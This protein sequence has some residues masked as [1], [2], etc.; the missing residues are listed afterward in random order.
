MS[1]IF[2]PPIPTQQHKK[3]QWG[4]L[5]PAASALAIANLAQQINTP[6][7]LITE[8]LHAAEQLQNNINF[9]NNSPLSSIFPDREILPYDH[10]SPHPDLTSDRLKLL[11]QLPQMTS[12][13]IIAA[14]PTLLS[15][16]PPKTFI[17]CHTCLFKIGMSLDTK[18]FRKQLT[19]AGYKNTT[20][21]TEHGEWLMRGS[22]IDIFP[23]GSDNPLRI[24][25]LDD[26]IDSLR[27]FDVETQRTIEKIEA[28]EILPATE[29]P[30]TDEAISHFRQSWRSRFSGNPMESPIY[31]N[32]SQGHA[33]PGIENYLPLF[34]ET[35]ASLID[36][37]P[38][39]TLIITSSSLSSNIEQY[40]KKIDYRYEQYRYDLSR[41]LCQPNQLFIS[42]E[43]LLASIAQFNKIIIQSS[44]N[45]TAHI[46][47]NTNTLPELSIQHKEKNPLKSFE[48][49]LRSHTGRCL[50]CAESSGRQEV[51]EDQLLA[52]NIKP[53]RYTTWDDFIADPSPIGIITCPLNAGFSIQQSDISIITEAELYGEQAVLQRK[54]R[55]QR[56]IDPDTLIKSLAEL[57]INDPVVHID[58]GIGKYLGLKNI[59]NNGVEAEFLTLEYANDAKIYVP[60]TSLHLISRYTGIDSKHAPLNTLGSA[61]WSKSKKKA[62]EKI[63]D[64]AAELLELNAKRQALPGYSFPLD[65]KEFERFQA[66]FSFQL[67]VDQELAIDAILKDMTSNHSMDRLICGDVGFGKTEVAMQAAFIAAIS[68]K[69]TSILVPTTLLANQHFQSFSDRFANWP[70][71]VG[72]ISR[73]QSTKQQRETLEQVAK[74]TIDIIIG[75]HKLLQKDIKIHDLGL[76]I[77]DE[78]HRFGVR[79]KEQIK[80]IRSE[81]DILSLTATPIPRTLNMALAGSR[82]I[83]IIAT[84]PERRLSI[85]TFVHDYS[86]SIIKEAILRESMRGGQLYCL[87]NDIATIQAMKEKLQA[88]SPDSRIA[89]AHGQMPKA[90]LEKI[91]SDFYHQKFNILLATTIIESGIDVPSANTIIINKADRFGLSQLH[92]LRG[93]V[94]RSHHQAYAYL[95]VEDQKTLSKDAKQRLEAIS[96]LED[97]GAGFTLATHDLEI[98]GAGEFLGEQQ[99]GH[100]QTLGYALY[101][102][103]LEQATKQLQAGEKPSFNL[104][105]NQYTE[106]DLG[107]SALIPD[108]YIHDVNTRLTLYKRINQC[109]DTG[110]LDELKAEVIDRFGPLA[111]S[112]NTLFLLTSLARQTTPLG[113]SKIETGTEYGY[114]TFIK[115]PPIEPMKIITLIQTKPQYYRMHKPNCLRFKIKTP[116]HNSKTDAIKSIIKTLS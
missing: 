95:L 50:I 37:L 40:W 78:E 24:E 60:V 17:N 97:L 15:Y 14:I 11:H 28:L 18:I 89:I 8:D 90:Q 21:V 3:T 51:I 83:S 114:I 87:H 111:D 27:Y 1:L 62:L 73:L 88:I 13:I 98:R 22:I 16:L 101:M 44:E 7:L 25:L 39:N 20:Q 35:T 52:S 12:G 103:M 31:E 38:T 115:D 93:R 2:T 70:V 9:F 113:I 82:D 49:F 63:H 69:Q 92:Q 64:V 23:I 72:I 85:K 45:G 54:V 47:F 4:E 36:Y 68:G 53:K 75:T 46:T 59:T 107:I 32:I 109:K 42:S 108:T 19:E 10:F 104:K 116:E 48:S 84:P 74:G 56:V 110:M 43:K 102:E 61:Q 33:S 86:N 106:I 81:V 96:Q 66:A 76:L 26:T 79:Q 34:F 67:T 65:R 29:Y 105:T 71:K 58:H 112:T 94:G 77:V 80:S 5:T 30:L 57:K 41:P 100:L 99:S 91:M 55:K 6:I